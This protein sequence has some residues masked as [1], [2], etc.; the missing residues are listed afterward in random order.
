[1]LPRC[2]DDCKLRSRLYKTPGEG[3]AIEATSQ[4]ICFIIANQ[5]RHSGNVTARVTL[6]HLI[7]TVSWMASTWQYERTNKPEGSAQYQCTLDW[8]GKAVHKSVCNCM[9]STAICVE[10][11]FARPSRQISTHMHL[12]VKTEHEVTHS[13]EDR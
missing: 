9:R 6:S 10:F 4:R 7:A 11:K 3:T 8:E 13:C 5:V 1:M 2:Q 12:K